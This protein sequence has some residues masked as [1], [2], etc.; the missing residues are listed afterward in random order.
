[1]CFLKS[2]K[3]P[4]LKVTVRT[5]KWMVGIRSF[6]FGMGFFAGFFRA[7]LVSGRVSCDSCRLPRCQQVF[8]HTPEKVCQ[9][10]RALERAAWCDAAASGRT[11]SMGDSAGG[12]KG[13]MWHPPPWFSQCYGKHHG[14]T[15]MGIVKLL[16]YLVWRI[17]FCF[18]FGFWQGG[19]ARLKKVT[20]S[21]NL[22]PWSCSFLGWAPAVRCKLLR[23]WGLKLPVHKVKKEIRWR[24]TVFTDFLEERSFS[25]GMMSFPKSFQQRNGGTNSSWRHLTVLRFWLASW[26][27]GMTWT[28][29][30]HTVDGQKIRLT[31]WGW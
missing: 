18:S 9:R 22:K 13:W 20:A 3:L 12:R 27:P 25:A 14:S 30:I 31:S 23:A 28:W 1:M 19:C 4:S 24:L 17:F 7:I 5:W 21:W 6:P 16:N 11:S 8:V 26:R 29:W 15:R 2:W 10:A